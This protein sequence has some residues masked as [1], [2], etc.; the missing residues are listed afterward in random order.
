[1]SL[2][3]RALGVVDAVAHAAVS[4]TLVAI[5]NRRHPLVAKVCAIHMTAVREALASHWLLSTFDLVPTLSV[6][7]P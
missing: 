1:M 6:S 3:W 7:Q 4:V 2:T 5:D